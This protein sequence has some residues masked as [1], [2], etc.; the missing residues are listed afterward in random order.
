MKILSEGKYWLEFLRPVATPSKAI[1]H[2]CGSFPKSLEYK[3]K[4]LVVIL[5]SKT[6]WLD[7]GTRGVLKAD[8]R[9]AFA[10]NLATIFRY[11]K[12]IR[13]KAAFG[14]RRL[15]GCVTLGN[16]AQNPYYE[17]CINELAYS[18][19]RLKRKVRVMDI[20]RYWGCW[21][22]ERFLLTIK[23]ILVRRLLLFEVPS[24]FIDDT[25][26]LTDVVFGSCILILLGIKFI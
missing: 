12:K 1:H 13:K 4:C 3:V 2:R 10:G 7:V 20:V 17:A 21:W 9:V 11:T 8:L 23:L 18:K 6:F 14:I 5:M 19:Q 15:G 25:R 26:G 22:N 24:L 16:W